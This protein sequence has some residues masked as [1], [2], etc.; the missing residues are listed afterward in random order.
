MPKRPYLRLF[1]VGLSCAITTHAQ[2]LPSEV[3]S[4]VN[5]FQDDFDGATLN[6]NWVVRGQPVYSVSGGALRVTST[7][8]DPN[9]LLYEVAGYDSSVQEVLARIRVTSFGTGDPSRAGISTVIDPV[10]SQGINWFFRDEPSAGQRH[11]EFLDDA[12]AWGTELPFAWQN[13]TWY[14]LRLRHEPNATSQGG[15]NDVF[16]KIWLADGSQPE[17]ASWQGTYDY[18]PA[19]TARSGFAGIGATSL[20][21]PAEFEVDYV[22]IKAGGLPSITVA[23]NAFVSTPA[24][25]TNQPQN[26]TVVEGTPATFIVGARGNPPPTYQWYRDNV[27]IS[28]ATNSSYTLAAVQ[29]TDNGAIFKAVAQNFV[30]NTFYTIGSSNAVLTVIGDDAPPTLTSAQAMGLTQVLVGFSERVQANS[31][32]NV[33]NYRITNASGS[34][35]I[36]NAALDGS[37]SN[38]FLNVATLAEGATYTLV[39][40]NIADLAGNLIAANTRTNFSAVSFTP[41]AIG[42]PQPAGGTVPAAGGLNLIAGGTDLGGTSDQFQFN[43]QTRTDNFDVRV[44]VASLSLADAWSEAG[45]IARE[46]LNAG[47]RF[48]GAFATPSISGS[49]FQ[50]RVTAA[51]AATIAG[52]FPVNYPNTWLRLQRVGNL[53]TGY[54][55]FDGVAWTALGSATV[56]MP[57]SVYVGFAASSH[58]TSQTTTAAFRDFSNVTSPSALTGPLP[59]EPL[60]QSSRRTSLVISEIMYNPADRADG[61]NVEFVELFNSLATPEDISG[62][63]LDGDADFTF[64]PGTVIPGGGF[65]VIAQDPADVQAVYGITG[66]L[67][68]FSNTNSLPNDR[69]TIQLRNR[70]GAVFL[71]ANY[72]TES[73]W[74]TSADGAGHSLVLARPSYGEG[75]ARPWA[76]SDS[77]GGSPGADDSVTVDPLRNVVINEFLAHTDLPQV[78][79]IELYNHGNQAVDISGCFLSDD[80]ETNKF[81]IPPGTVL[82][83]RTF[84][85]FDQNQLGFA[86]SSGGE[87]IY[88]RDAANTRVIDAVRFEAQANGVSSGRY[89]DGAPTFSELASVTQGTNNAALPI[90]PV[91][92]NEIMYNPISHDSDDEFIELHNRGTTAA[93]VG[94]WRIAG[95][96]SHT[97]AANTTIPAGGYLVIARD[98]TRLIS[99]YPNLN[100]A[101]TVG[102]F[103]GSLANGGERVALAMPD[104]VLTTNNNTVITNYNYIVVDEVTYREGGRW[105]QW[106]DGGGSSLELIDPRS[107]NRLAA[108]WADSDESAK[109]PWTIFSVSGI[110]DH[111]TSAADQLQV[112]LQGAGECL[113]DDVEV[114]NP[115]GVNLIANSTFESGATGWTAEGTQS[116]SSQETSE[117]YASARSYHVRA[118]D[119]GDNQVNRIRT[120]LTA[121]QASGLTNTIRAKVRWLRGHPEILFR[122]RGNWHEAAVAMDLPTNLGTPGARNSRALNN[123][124]PAIS[125]VVHHPAV[126]AA[127]QPV[128][129]TAR[130]HDPDGLAS[131]QLRYRLDPSAALTNL[132]MLDNGTGGDAVA[133]DGLFAAT[134]P[135]Q[136]N[137]TLVAFHVQ[138]TDA[139]SPSSTST[140]PTTVPARE[141]L[142]RFGESVPTGNFPSY[143]IW[144]TQASFNAWDQR[145]N[146]NNTLNDVTFVLGNHRVIYNV[147]ATYA[148]SPYIG[149][150]FDTPTGRRCGYTIEIPSDDM[151]LGDN[152][153]VLDWPGGHGNENT[154]IQEQM[155]YWIADQIDLAFSHR[156]FIRLTINGVT[157]MQRGGVFEAA[158]QPGSDFLEQWSPGDS[159]GEFYKIDRAFEFSD[160]GGLIADPEPQLQVY[161]TR[162]LV[163]GGMK[164]KLE[165][166][167]WYWLKRAYDSAN[168]YS[169]LLVLAD[170]L[171]SPAPE[172]YTTQAEALADIEQ[173]M[174]IFCV[175]HIINNFDSWGHDIG[176]NMYMFKPPSGKWQLYMFDL[177][178]LM[179]VSPS[180]PGGYTALS[181]PLFSSDDPTVTRMYNHPPFRRAYLRTVENAVNKAFVQAKYEAV[182]DAKYNSLVANGITLCDGQSLAAPTAVKTW[183]S[184]RRTYLVNQLNAVAAAFAITSN[185]GSNFTTNTTA[186]TLAGTAPITV[187]GIRINGMDYPI[188]WT[189]VTAWSLRIPLTNGVNSITLEPYDGAGNSIATLT[190]SI[191]VTSTATPESPVGRVVINEIMYNPTVP[192]AEFVEIY[193]TSATTTF[194]IS[195]WRIN[196]VDFEFAGGTIIEPGAF[197][198]VAKDR[199]IFAAT[200]SSTNNRVVG[201]F[202]GELDGGGETLTL[203]KPGFPPATDLVVD[204]VTYDDDLPWPSAPDGNGPSLQLIDASQDNSRVANW[205]DGSGW[206]FLSVTG[207]PGS[208]ATDL[209]LYLASAGDVYVD[210]VSVVAGTQ[211]GV[212]S[213]YVANGGFETGA[214]DP[215]RTLGGYT[216]SAVSGAV[217]FSGNY[218]LHIVGAGGGSPGSTVIQTHDPLN[219]SGTYT[220]SLWYLPS[221]NGTGLHFR[222][223]TP[224][225]TV[226]AINYRPI[227]ASPGSPNPTAAPMAEFPKL[228]INEIQP[229]NLTGIADNGGDRDPWVELYNSGTNTIDL[230]GWYLADNYTNLTRWAFPPGTSVAPGQFLLVWL[231][232]EPAESTGSALH[233]SFRISPT[234][235]SLALVFPLDAH[236]AV[237]D[238]INYSSI[239]ERSFGYYP[240]GEFGLRESFFVTTPGAANDN[241]VAP[242]PVLINEWMAA[243]TT[244]VTDPADGDFDDWFELYNPNDVAVDLTDYSLSD[245]LTVGGARWS[246]PSGTTIPARGFLLV[247]ADNETGQNATNR[248]DLHAG[249]QL[250]QAG[251]AIGLFA[252][253][254]TVVDSVTFGN[255]TNNISQGR[256]RDGAQDL[257]FM[258]SPTPRAANVIP[259]TPPGDIE[260]LSA[261][262]NGTGQF[263]ITWSAEPGIS[264]RV[265]F[266][267]DLGAAWQNLS[268]VEAVG[269]TASVTDS[270]ATSPP[271]RFYRIQRISP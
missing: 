219:A 221:T 138:A 251:E 266:K 3:G 86:L 237:L 61:R 23:P 144:M 264:Y 222:Y 13:N 127:N 214:M 84:F 134:I 139:F 243:N 263:V 253:N 228:W 85:S 224:F 77:V 115:A 105:G 271:Q 216:N 44:R 188:T 200:Y 98:A 255:Q 185:G 159:D 240:D 111:G 143:R 116:Q 46:D 208:A 88:F 47:G 180:G 164:K 19:R 270:L 60:G 64:A 107:D 198:V 81:T 102:D 235:G 197:L 40:N 225:R 236:P 14:W 148:G 53:F 137:G 260:I 33:T 192:G 63:R 231:D 153:L 50:A 154:A 118:T 209:L 230:T 72:D 126:P 201:E 99:R 123:A 156:Y 7:T 140:F 48:A 245:V 150:S 35:A 177:D 87:R 2:F 232:G 132:T 155:A 238:Y 261:A 211:P 190:D 160:G 26:L 42:N 97:I 181:G 141:C 106:S 24:T 83:P 1:V 242:L 51:A 69:G 213:N 90:R 210:E 187:R 165:K 233:T 5:G 71:E 135:G 171:N 182:M 100:T 205:T 54:A 256:W 30:S 52:S 195:G 223:T 199:D 186:V 268:N 74:P 21:G 20:G 229:N 220:F 28:G 184:Q 82:Q 193:N 129:V 95:G 94:G 169:N 65:L 34:I 191:N 43:Y 32:T 76:S 212:G 75:D 25:I 179:L 234:A 38:V 147:G 215:W 257:Y 16:G 175:E 66:V 162:D 168:D 258:P 161:N 131:V 217:A 167:R 112:L 4:A 166:Y 92:I 265:Q 11:I 41:I 113:I 183:F 119:R 103:N 39:L 73:P 196:G 125:D 8:G 12:R 96:I 149:P 89:P 15:I 91:V 10:S 101:N 78:D 121:A 56:S 142:V 9:H 146:L 262:F 207:T 122:L 130:V 241:T 152:A 227:P 57:A 124:P 226:S 254:G 239:G 267:D 250:R 70:I 145:H 29:L 120:P 194:D 206:R 37:Q 93:N 163:N 173:M 36:V 157:D 202:A 246:I 17:P 151:F 133:G 247:W 80:R 252:P 59:R 104:P 27:A 117:G 259:F 108:N 62:W 248:A 110:L 128:V 178:W 189:S 114:L 79:F 31:A 136:G 22:L 67:G 170:V 45:L 49:Y 244:F 58:N 68:P 204:I 172:P 218:S 249:F 55:S 174:G 158:Q 176:K 18:I 109:A 6:P 203:I 269:A